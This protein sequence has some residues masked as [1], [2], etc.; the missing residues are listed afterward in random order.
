MALDNKYIIA[1]VIIFILIVL[2]II[3]LSSSKDNPLAE[4]KKV[5][6]YIKNGTYSAP[7]K[8]D[9]SNYPVSSYYGSAAYQSDL[10]IL[11]QISK[12]TTQITSLPADCYGLSTQVTTSMTPTDL[13]KIANNLL[14]K[15]EPTLLVLCDKK[16]YANMAAV[17]VLFFNMIYS[18]MGLNGANF[19]IPTYDSNGNLLT[20][21][22]ANNIDNSSNVIF[23]PVSYYLSILTEGYGPVNNKVTV[24]FMNPTQISA[25]LTAQTISENRRALVTSVITNITN[26]LNNE[27]QTLLQQYPN[28]TLDIPAEL[29][30]KLIMTLL[31]T[32]WSG[33][34]TYNG[35]NC[36]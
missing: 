35:L 10:A 31:F 14:L 27:R 16:Q 18:L 28:S 32:V 25:F 19:I 6:Q 33:S 11:L 23:L 12:N 20:I 30:S 24:P 17:L 21:K 7:R 2:L 15:I 3:I 1:G 13:Q 34:V 8:Q 22:Y 26:P 4:L 9:T 5:I 36:A 29:F